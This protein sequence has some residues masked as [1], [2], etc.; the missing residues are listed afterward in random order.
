MQLESVHTYLG[1]QE[2]QEEEVSFTGKR[3]QRKKIDLPTLSTPSIVPKWKKKQV[4]P[5]KSKKRSVQPL[6]GE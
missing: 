4:S 1:M 6:A 3:A 5:I 2:E